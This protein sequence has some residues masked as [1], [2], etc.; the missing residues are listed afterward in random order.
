MYTLQRFSKGAEYVKYN[1]RKK[2]LQR[3]KTSLNSQKGKCFSVFVFDATVYNFN[4][5][6]IFGEN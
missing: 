3:T 2:N 5:V 6:Q 4:T 1:L